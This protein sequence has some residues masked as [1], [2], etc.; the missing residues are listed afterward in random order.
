MTMSVTIVGAG[1]GGLTLARV[2]HLHGIAATIYEAD[3]SVDARIQGGQLDIHEHDGQRALTAA[4]LTDAF[5]AIIHRGGEATRALDWSGKVLLDQP[6]DGGGGRP[7]VLRGDLRRILINSLPPDTIRWGFKLCEVR[8]I[9]AGRHE[10]S[11]IN[12]S[13]AIADILVGADGAWSRVRPLL[14]DAKPAY[15]GVSYIETY[16]HDV[17]RRFPATAEAVG[18]GG[19]F[20]LTPGKGFSAHREAGNV[21]HTY[22]QL[23]RPA[24]WFLDID[25]GDAPK[26]KARIATEFAGWAPQLTS[27]ITGGDAA[28]VLRMINALP[29]GHKWDRKPGVTLIGDAAHLAPPAGDGANLAMLDGAELGEALV[30]RPDDIERALASYEAAMFRRSEAAA[31]DAYQIMDLC[32]GEHAPFGLIE[33]LSSR[34][35]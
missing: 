16:L 10:L 5:D 19:M 9:G 17:D 29:V 20:A 31:V 26:A 25:F 18:R 27:L 14:S 35:R 1:L 21:L 15:T 8:S 11:F 34:L 33:M 12:G 2:L 4:H 28:P 23:K 32:L 13:T 30:A 7:E 3:S 6:D 22:V 24:D